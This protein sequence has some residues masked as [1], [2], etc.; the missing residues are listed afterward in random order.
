MAGPKA[1]PYGVFKQEQRNESDP[2]S[3]FGDIKNKQSEVKPRKNTNHP[4]TN[5]GQYA[6]M[7]FHTVGVC[8]FRRTP[9]L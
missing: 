7:V 4:L 5:G 3:R 8:D 6:K 1:L 2:Q 9:P